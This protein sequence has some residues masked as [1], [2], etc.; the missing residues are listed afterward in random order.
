MKNTFYH[1]KVIEGSKTWNFYVIVAVLIFQAIMIIYLSTQ[2]DFIIESPYIS[3]DASKRDFCSMVMSQM[4]ERKL[5][6]KLTS[7][8]LYEVVTKDNYSS[9]YLKGS[10]TIKA[11]WSNDDSCKLLI[12]GDY[13]RSF[14]FYLEDSGEYPY[15]FVVQKITEHDLFE[16]E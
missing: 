15:H 5:S 14:D 2:R 11:I 8:G 12:K 10:E 16:K 9:L 6:S 1:D 7:E 13:L 3:N 4:I